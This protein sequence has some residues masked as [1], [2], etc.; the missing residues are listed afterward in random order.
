MC[1]GVRSAHGRISPELIVKAFPH[2]SEDPSTAGPGRMCS[3]A[4]TGPAPHTRSRRSSL[5]VWCSFGQVVMGGRAGRLLT[6][7]PPVLSVWS[8]SVRCRSEVWERYRRSPYCHSS[9]LWQDGADQTGDGLAVGE[10]LD[11]V[12]AALDLAVEALDGV[13]AAGSWPGARGG[14]VVAKAVGSGWASIGIRAILK[15]GRPLKCR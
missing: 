4:P 6:P 11:D 10:D 13:A 5:L 7:S 14:G 2:D 12:C 3:T 15:G 1:R 9:L 8:M